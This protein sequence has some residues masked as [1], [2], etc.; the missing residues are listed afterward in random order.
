MFLFFSSRRRHTSCALVTG[1][2]TCA[3]PILRAILPC[4]RVPRRDGSTTSRDRP[5]SLRPPIAKGTRLCRILSSLSECFFE[6]IMARHVSP[7]RLLC[8]FVALR[9]VGNFRSEEC[10]VGKEWV[11]TCRFG[12]SPYNKKQKYTYKSQKQKEH[13]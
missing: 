2:Q 11:R 7:A 4:V 9:T 6:I 13:H 1:V 5:S 8:W 3:L 12:G 10:R